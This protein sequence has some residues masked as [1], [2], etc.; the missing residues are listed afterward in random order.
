M[1]SVPRARARVCVVLAKLVIH[2]LASRTLMTFVLVTIAVFCCRCS[3]YRFV[4]GDAV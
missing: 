4:V 3:S 1:T 2:A